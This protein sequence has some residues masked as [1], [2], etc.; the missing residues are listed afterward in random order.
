MKGDA[1]DGSL[2]FAEGGLGGVFGELV[3]EDGFVCSY[4][5]RIFGNKTR[6]L[7]EADSPSA[8]TVEK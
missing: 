6:E 5:R 8:E 3:D 2:S 7:I 4:E 1:L